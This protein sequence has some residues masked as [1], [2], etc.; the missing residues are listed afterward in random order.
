MRKELVCLP[1]Q[2]M[3]LDELRAVFPLFCPV[4]S[5]SSSCS[6]AERL[7]DKTKYQGFPV[8]KSR[9]DKTLLGDISRRDLKIA[10]GA[11]VECLRGS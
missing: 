10:I 4:S 9:K 7:L 8:V 5:D 11:C 1:S 6:P 3:K 2:G